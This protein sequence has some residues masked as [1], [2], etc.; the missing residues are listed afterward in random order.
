LYNWYSVNTGKLCPTGWH[1]PTDAQ[2]TTL[3]EYFGGDN[4]AGG[5]LKETGITHWNSPNTAATNE[6]GFSALPGGYRNMGGAFGSIGYTGNWWSSTSIY[7]QWVG[8]FYYKRIMNYNSSN[9]NSGYDVLRE[10]YS[11]RCLKDN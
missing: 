2:L 9:V 11:V 8:T 3:T 10:G 7:I 5:K 1:V 4:A 6:S